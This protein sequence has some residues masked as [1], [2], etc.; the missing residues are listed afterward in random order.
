MV[1]PTDSQVILPHW[2]NILVCHALEA[3][4]HDNGTY[5]SYFTAYFFKPCHESEIICI[6]SYES[7]AESLNVSPTDCKA[8]QVQQPPSPTGTDPGCVDELMSQPATLTHRGTWSW[9]HYPL[10]PGPKASLVW[11]SLLFP[12]SP[13]LGDSFRMSLQCFLKHSFCSTYFF[14]N[15]T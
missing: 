12:S 11:M 15:P 5:V 3:L 6:T 13:Q 4:K 2:L 14:F 10:T 9:K 7:N 8:G 1:P